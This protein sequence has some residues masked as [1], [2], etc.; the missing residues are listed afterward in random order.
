MLLTVTAL[1]LG[2]GWANQAVH[3]WNSDRLGD[4][5]ASGARPGDIR[6]LSS[7]V[8]E[9]CAAARAWFERND[10][11]YAECFI[12]NDA[13]CAAEFAKSGSPGTPVLMVRGTKLVGFR[14]DEVLA[15][16]SAG[17]PVHPQRVQ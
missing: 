16:L 3:R 2:V 4:Q 14:A 8:C 10:V 13:A 17:R 6:M 9:Y 11:P 1:V 12:E 15:A 7:V 5:V